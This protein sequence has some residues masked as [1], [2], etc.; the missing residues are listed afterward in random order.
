MKQFLLD[1]SH[2]ELE[3]LF[4]AWH[5]PS[6]RVD[7]VSKWIYKN[8]ASSF[9]EM[10]DLPAGLR[11]RLD[12]ETSLSQL[13]AVEELLSRDGFTRKW[14][15]SLPDETQIETVLMRYDRRQTACIST[16]AGC[17][18]RCLFCAT[19]LMGIKHSLS[20]GQIVEQVLFI[21]RKLVSAAKPSHLSNI[22]IMGMGEPFANYE[23]T[24]K[25][26]RNLVDP[27]GFG[28][29][30]RRI[31]L[32]TVGLVPGIERFAGEG[33]QV[34]LSI[35][36]HAA[37]DDLR[38]KLV[39]VNK[40]YKLE[41]LMRSVRNYIDST[42]RRVTFEWVLIHGMNDSVEDA[43]ALVS[44]VQGMLC[45]VNLIPINPVK[46]LSLE[47]SPRHAIEAFQRELNQAGIPNTVRMR[48]GQDIQAG[49]GQLCT[50]ELT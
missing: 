39:P 4:F 43:R 28:I 18:M 19:G 13:Q 15:L 20:A 42:N 7:Q 6:Y 1:M 3:N 2:E 22:V 33:L 23:N 45:H 41:D 9:E 31:T 27:K 44:L 12:G 10:S 49:C 34:N 37:T 5:E 16:Q 48:R 47:V 46:G 17:G 40:R 24:I 26:I 32:S 36:L 38:S 11:K 35:S 14:V 29:G 50:E 8:L 30:A 21:A 25:A